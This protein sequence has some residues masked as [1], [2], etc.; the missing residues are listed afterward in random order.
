MQLQSTRDDIS[1][2]TDEKATREAEFGYS[3]D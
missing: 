3:R 2:P 1:I